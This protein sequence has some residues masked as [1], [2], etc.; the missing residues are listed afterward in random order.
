MGNAYYMYDLSGTRPTDATSHRAENPRSSVVEPRNSS[1]L[2]W[3]IT[4]EPDPSDTTLVLELN[5]PAVA[6]YVTPL[7][8]E[9][10]CALAHDGRLDYTDG[11]HVVVAPVGGTATPLEGLTR[12]GGYFQSSVLLSVP[13][14]CVRV[15]VAASD[16]C[17]HAAVD[18]VSACVRTT[19]GCWSLAWG[20][21]GHREFCYDPRIPS[22]YGAINPDGDLGVVFG[23]GDP[24]TATFQVFDIASVNVGQ[25]VECRM[26]IRVPGEEAAVSPYRHDAH[27][28]VLRTYATFSHLDRPGSGGIGKISATIRG[29]L[30]VLYSSDWHWEQVDIVSAS[31]TD[32][33]VLGPALGRPSPAAPLTAPPAP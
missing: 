11:I 13:F 26:T 16:S 24:A 17:G 27:S 8:L 15:T 29:S 33:T 25:E 12:G 19:P 22:S 4:T 9:V 21:G 3:S 31:F 2:F 1:G 30:G 28:P 5:F 14:S 6:D 10:R 32:I 20:A 7:P 18:S 23:M